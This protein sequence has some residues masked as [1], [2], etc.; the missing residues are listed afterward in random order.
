MSDTNANPENGQNL[1]V[2]EESLNT[3]NAYRA[4]ARNLV[5]EIGQSEVRKQ[6][7]IQQ[8]ADVEGRAQGVI[9]KIQKAANIPDGVTFTLTPEGDITFPQTDPAPTPPSA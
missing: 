2:D 3:L 5:Y 8:L 4:A 9:A 7:L 6:R 1:K